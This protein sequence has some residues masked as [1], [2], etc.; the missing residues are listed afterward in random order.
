[1]MIDTITFFK[2]KLYKSS[3][4]LDKVRG[5]L[6]AKDREIEALKKLNEQLV[7]DNHVLQNERLPF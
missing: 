1:M 7:Y 4:M 5:K 6:K 3:R 2:G